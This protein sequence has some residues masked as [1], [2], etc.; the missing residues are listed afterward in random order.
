MSYEFFYEYSI[1]S[2]EI[3]TGNLYLNWRELMKVNSHANAVEFVL[4]IGEPTYYIIA[5][6]RV[7]QL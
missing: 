7:L 6:N 5:T 1:H 2:H 4:T 3:S